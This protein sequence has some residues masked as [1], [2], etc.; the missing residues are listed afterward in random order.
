MST[1]ATA[2]ITTR[3]SSQVKSDDP[4]TSRDEEDGTETNCID[5]SA[6]KSREQNKEVMG[7]PSVMKATY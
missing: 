5:R 3:F 6:G 2:R 1:K 7:V 4:G